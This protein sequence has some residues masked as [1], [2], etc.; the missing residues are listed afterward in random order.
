MNVDEFVRQ[1]RTRTPAR[2]GIEILAPQSPQGLA[3]VERRLGTRLPPGV[4]R[5]Y[6]ALDG[7]E[8]SSPRLHVFRAQSL[9]KDPDGRIAF[10]EFAGR[11]R[12]VFLA[13]QLNPAQEWSI[14]NAE[15]GFVVTL[16]MASFWSNK[17]FAWL[18]RQRPVWGPE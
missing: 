16:T 9:S 8:V 10:A 15:T 5:F 7:F 12:L 3:E 1:L 2:G 6:E 17:V 4:R 13:N 18:D 11:H 14:A